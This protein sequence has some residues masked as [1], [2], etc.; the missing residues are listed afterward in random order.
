VAHDTRAFIAWAGDYSLCPLPQTQR[1]AGELEAPLERVWRGEQ[2]LK[3]VLRED[4]HGQAKRIAQGYE[5]NQPMSVEV[6][7][8]PREGRERRLVV[9]SLRHAQRRRPGFAPEWRRPRPKSK[10][11]T[12]EGEAASALTI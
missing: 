10:R 11:S 12:F 6:D 3:E 4:E 1:G 2:G 9:R 7:G 8:M 5:S